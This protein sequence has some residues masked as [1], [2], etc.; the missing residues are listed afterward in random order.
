MPRCT[1]ASLGDG[2]KRLF[3]QVRAAPPGSR[4]AATRPASRPALAELLFR[5][6]ARNWPDTLTPTSASAGTTIAAARS[7]R[8]SGLSE[9]TFDCFAAI[10]RRRC[11][12]L[13]RRAP[14]AG[15]AATRWSAGAAT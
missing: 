12:T 6:R 3:A 11:A 13:R 8:D 15:A 1:T 7:A 10:D 5:Y 9:Y 14:T 4:W 2:D